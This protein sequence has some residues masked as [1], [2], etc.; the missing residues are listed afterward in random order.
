VNDE[1]FAV[2]CFFQWNSNE[3]VH[4]QEDNH[5]V[6]APNDHSAI[7]IYVL[8]QT[9]VFEV[10]NEVEYFHLFLLVHFRKVLDD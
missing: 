1:L 8:L 2:V 5:C 4:L 7:P 10:I 9:K 3:L 6:R